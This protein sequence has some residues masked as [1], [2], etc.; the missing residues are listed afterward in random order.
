M[1]K[2]LLTALIASLL[3]IPFEGTALALTGEA[4]A[5]KQALDYSPGDIPAQ[6]DAVE[7]MSPALHA[8]VLSM[9]HQ[10][11]PT[12]DRSN[13]ELAWESLYNF[14]SLYGQM[15]RRVEL[16]DDMLYLPEETAQDYAAAL[17]L[18][19]DEMGTLPAEILD[20]LSYDNVSHCY[21]VTP[22]EDGLSQIQVRNI[23]T[24]A[25]GLQLT[26]ALIYTPSGRD[27]VRFQAT[28]QPRDNMFGYTLTE[29]ILTD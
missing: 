4:S 8:L 15:D 23:Q 16:E 3:V 20:R 1:K 17:D 9:D 12:F 2:L 19:L 21:G 6:T 24:S 26:G 10:E 29:M 25:S 27:L 5:S 11:A 7:A 18:N 28:L 14:L 22:G 13:R